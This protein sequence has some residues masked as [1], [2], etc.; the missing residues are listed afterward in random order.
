MDSVRFCIAKEFRFLDFQIEPNTTVD[1][2]SNFLVAASEVSLTGRGTR[3]S[4]GAAGR[5]GVPTPSSVRRNSGFEGGGGGVGSGSS[6]GA[7]HSS[8]GLEDLT[9]PSFA[10]TAAMKPFTGD[11]SLIST[12]ALPESPFCPPASPEPE[13]QSSTKPFLHRGKNRSSSAVL[14]PMVSSASIITFSRPYATPKGRGSGTS[15]IPTTGTAMTRGKSSQ[16]GGTPSVVGYGEGKG[17]SQPVVACIRAAQAAS[18]VVL[19]TIMDAVHVGQVRVSSFGTSH[20]GVSWS[21]VGKKEEASSGRGGFHFV[22]TAL[23]SHES[24]LEESP[25]R[26]RSISF[27]APHAM[28][29]YSVTEGRLGNSPPE[30]GGPPISFLPISP[31]ASSPSSTF[32]LPPSVHIVLFCAQK[33]YT[34]LLSETDRAAFALSTCI[35]VLSTSQ[36]N[37]LYP[38]NLRHSSF[39]NKKHLQEVLAFPEMLD[40]VSVS[41][42]VSGYLRHLLLILRGSALP[43]DTVGKYVMRYLPRYLRLIRAA[44]LLFY[45]GVDFRTPPE[46]RHLLMPSSSATFSS[47]GAG[48]SFLGLSSIRGSAREG[49]SVSRRAPNTALNTS[50]SGTGDSSVDV[51]GDANLSVHGNTI[52]DASPSR[53]VNPSHSASR[54]STFADVVVTPTDV[55]CLLS[56]MI[57]HLFSIRVAQLQFLLQSS[58]SSPSPSALSCTSFVFPRDSVPSPFSFPKGG[59]FSLGTSSPRNVRELAQHPPS[60]GR[61]HRMFSSF[62]PAGSPPREAEPPS[63]RSGCVPNGS[64]RSSFLHPRSE[65]GRRSGSEITFSR[66][67]EGETLREEGE[68]GHRNGVSDAPMRSSLSPRKRNAEPFSNVGNSLKER[69]NAKREEM[70]PTSRQNSVSEG[71]LTAA[72]PA[73]LSYAEVREFLRYVIIRYSNP[74]PG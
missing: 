70:N 9:V 63:L 20:A 73:A 11:S 56:P 26:Q 66:E 41:A 12:L 36:L 68:E 42:V 32:T 38:V 14:S 59:S 71:E 58:S 53:S 40:T 18:P 45:P 8:S 4:A 57:A 24:E 15:V 30:G 25:S 43:G 49:S 6:T 31:E 52:F 27:S 1:Q 7:L 60:S 62:M 37:L 19:Q 21:A 64:S 33:C 23:P 74:T 61:T 3:A 54:S 65:G 50:G 72:G 44:A 34:E 69:H 2:I 51:P 28:D 16:F 17:V 39:L 47:P 67:R 10:A 22:D 5:N 48:N 46:S 55:L 29:P 13:V 35:S